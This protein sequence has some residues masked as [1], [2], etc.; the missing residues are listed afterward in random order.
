MLT[1]TITSAV[2]VAALVLGCGLPADAQDKSGER[3]A[4][5][6]EYEN[7]GFALN[8]LQRAH[9]PD[10]DA[11][12]A[13][14]ELDPLIDPAGGGACAS[15]VCADLMQALRVM[16]GLDRYPNPHKVALA[17]FRDQ[18]AL[19]K[20]RVS[21]EQ[22]VR[23]IAFYQSYLGHAKVGVDVVSAPNSGYRTHHRTWAEAD[24]PD[25]DVSPRK[26]KVLSY[27]VT[28]P[29]GAVLGRHFVLLK[30]AAKDHI[31]VVDPVKPGAD[32]H[33]VLDFKPGE[34]EARARLFLNN[35]PGMPRTGGYVYEVNTVFTVSLLDEGELGKRPAPATASVESV[36]H[37]V[38]ETARE[39][40]G[41]NE[42]LDPR[43]WRKRTAAFGLPGLDLPA[44]YGGSGWPAVKMVD[45][46][47][48]A[49]WHN[50][51]FRDVVGGA[52]VRPLL[53]STNPDVLAVVRQVARG[54]GYVA[55][56]I[57]EP[58][59]GT[60]IPAIKSTAR[61]VEGGYLLNGAKRFNA[62]LDQA[63]HVVLFTQGTAGERGKLSAFVVPINSPGLTV[64]RLQAHGLTGNSYGGL[65]FKDL[66]VS[67]GQLLGKDGEGMG[68]FFEH[69]LYWRL[70][71]S[72]A[73]IG[74][75]ENAL[76]QMAARLKARQA[77][78]GPIGRFT[79]LQQPIGQYKTELRMAYALAREAAARIDRGDY[80]KE[81]R[82]LIC[83]IKAEGV[84]MALRATDA[85][86]RAF[87]GEGYSTLVDLGDRLRD[88]NGLRIADGT[89]D[90][91]RMEVV[92]QTFGEEFWDMA[93]GPKK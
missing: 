6:K 32:R 80:G 50:L 83:G 22:L 82:A 69:F 15:A 68:I 64:E 12:V 72:A 7:P 28:G 88:L 70:M 19:L 37:L 30:G 55:I 47:R 89:T 41:T 5:A 44:E 87:G 23:L 58:E 29:T 65:R 26:L 73:A 51:N 10:E 4:A 33:Y 67:D 1:R 57:T 71:Q 8:L 21:N 2:S 18:P 60:D 52:H 84:E 93:A 27:T 17:A 76:D 11:F 59:A 90:V 35:P 3:S 16:A 92:R 45:V 42:F 36:N 34:K 85:A 63:T 25:L 48:R 86:V 46:F 91:M 74:T 56:A 49:G 75:G 39:L 13:Q 40:K 77:F 62:R 20:G 43:A 38:D 79:H 53:K 81:T 54:D 31:D 24:G 66:K 78:G 14:G 61:K 9:G